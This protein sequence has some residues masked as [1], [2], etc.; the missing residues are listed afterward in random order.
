MVSFGRCDVVDAGFGT[1]EFLVSGDASN[2]VKKQMHD[3]G[4]DDS[5]LRVERG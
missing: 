5:S 4:D 2:G 1:A 3:V